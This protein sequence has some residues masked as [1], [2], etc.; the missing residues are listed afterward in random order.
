MYTKIYFGDGEFRHTTRRHTE[1]VFVE[2]PLDGERLDRAVAAELEPFGERVGGSGGGDD[3]FGMRAPAC[4]SA[5]AVLL[6]LLLCLH[7]F[8]R[9]RPVVCRVLLAVHLQSESEAVGSDYRLSLCTG[10]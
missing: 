1:Q 5:R 8:A 7:V 4:V 2:A 6:E 3:L 9:E 10:D